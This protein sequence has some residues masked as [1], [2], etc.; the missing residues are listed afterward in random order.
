MGNIC[1]KSD[2]E[3]NGVFFQFQNEVKK[4]KGKKHR[5][6]HILQKYKINSSTIIY[7]EEQNQQNTPSQNSII[8]SEGFQKHSK[9][10]NSYIQSQ[11]TPNSAVQKV[12]QSSRIMLKK[13]RDFSYSQQQLGAIQPSLSKSSSSNQN[14][15]GSR[16]QISSYQTLN[17][18]LNNNNNSEIE[19]QGKNLQQ[20][21]R[22]QL[23]S[24]LNQPQDSFVT[25]GNF[26]RLKHAKTLRF[27]HSHYIKNEH[28]SKN[29]EVSACNHQ[30]STEDYDLWEIIKIGNYQIFDSEIVQ[31]NISLLS[32]NEGL[33]KIIQDSNKEKYNDRYNYE[34]NKIDN[35]AQKSQ[36]PK[37]EIII[38]RQSEN[39]INGSNGNLY[40]HIN[41]YQK[42]DEKIQNEK[43]LE[44][45]EKQNNFFNQKDQIKENDN[46]KIIIDNNHD[47]NKTNIQPFKR[48]F[49]QQFQQ[50]YSQIIRK[51]L[52][53][54]SLSADYSKNLK[55]SELLKFHKDLQ[56][57]K[58][59]NQ[60]KLVKNLS[61]ISQKQQSP[62]NEND[63]SNIEENKA[64]KK[65][66]NNLFTKNI[67]SQSSNLC[68]NQEIFEF[69]IQQQLEDDIIRNDDIIVLKHK[70][71][72]KYLS[73]NQQ[74]KSRIKKEQEVSCQKQRNRHIFWKLQIK[75]KVK[76]NYIASK[77]K[78][79]QDFIQVLQLNDAINL[80]HYLTQNRLQTQKKIQSIKNNER[81]VY[82]CSKKTNDNYWI[83][84]QII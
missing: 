36:I 7:E 19:F 37:S 8:I 67:K 66:Q 15:L 46:E 16:V 48:R 58:G 62:N 27:L 61:K 44:N 3:A 60:L 28:G 35:D 18:S 56:Q 41:L 12:T 50:T 55:Q 39:N 6:L 11:D 80:T 49:S 78:G 10:D 69:K 9:I 26:I 76:K 75:G 14:L 40:D 45:N 22:S 21:F 54:R 32:D 74:F 34:I 24:E 43:I 57:K 71:T 77:Q 64:I 42:I 31:K 13:V 84:D 82:C 51:Q 5:Q 4:I 65:Y 17:L 38:E 68:Q 59:Q 2:E 47:T 79:V 81:E 83:V 30:D 29:Q 25:N 20:S 23:S 52:N 72:G 70:L 53:I 33:Q 73:S 63:K 1:F